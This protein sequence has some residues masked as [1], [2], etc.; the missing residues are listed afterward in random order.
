MPADIDFSPAATRAR[1]AAIAAPD[2]SALSRREPGGDHVLNPSLGHPDGARLKDAAVLIPIV[3]HPGEASVLLT[4]R[5]P[6]LSSHAGEVAFPG[7][8][9]DADDGSPI[10][11]ALREAQEEIGLDA[12]TISPVGYLDLYLSNSGYRITPVL[13][14][15][16]PGF[17]LTPNPDEV[18]NV[19]EVPLGFLMAPEN[20][21]RRSRHWRG[22]ERY[23]YE[24]PFE[25]HRIWGVTAGIIRR[26]YER[27]AGLR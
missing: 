25:Q 27:M 17:T 3:L 1:L 5:T 4:T 20:H 15:L 10:R 24:M 9:V 6:T 12:T 21:H 19:F 23:F 18:A 11:T 2:L 14:T 22:I 8:R 16:T 26:F 13:A 7:G